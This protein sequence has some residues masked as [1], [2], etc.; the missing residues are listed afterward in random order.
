MRLAAVL[1]LLTLSGC[2]QLL[3]R[4][5]SL[6]HCEYVKY[7]RKGTAAHL[8]ADCTLPAGTGFTL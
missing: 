6:E 8:E 5:P 3:S 1:L 7:E 2:S 4:L